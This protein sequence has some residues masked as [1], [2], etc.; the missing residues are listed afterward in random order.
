MGLRALRPSAAIVKVMSVP[1]SQCILVVTPDDHVNI[2]FHEVLLHDMEDDDLPFVALSELNCLRLEWPKTLFVFM[3]RYQCD[4]PPLVKAANLA[5]YFPQWTVTRTQWTEMTRPTIS[6]VAIDTLLFSRIGVPLF[7][8]YRIISRTGTPVFSRTPVF[9]GTYM[10]RLHA[11]LVG[12]GVSTSVPSPVRQGVG[13]TDVAVI[14]SRFSGQ[15]GGCFYSTYSGSSVS[16]PGPETSQA[17]GGV[18]L[19][20]RNWFACLGRKRPRYK[21]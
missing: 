21:N 8:H 3:S 6:G 20:R 1:D 11:F 16:L 15:N 13:G 12:C 4:V 9:W 2:G 14:R 10:R 18:L 19:R 5:R 17:G 7:H